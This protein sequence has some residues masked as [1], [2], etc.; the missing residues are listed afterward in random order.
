M[1]RPPWE[2][3][4]RALLRRSV[5]RPLLG[6]AIG[7]SATPAPLEDLVYTT[8]CGSM[9]PTIIVFLDLEIRA[10][11]RTLPG[12]RTRGIVSRVWS[13]W[14]WRTRN[15][16]VGR[17]VIPPRQYRVFSPVRTVWCRLQHYREKPFHPTDSCRFRVSPR[18]FQV[19]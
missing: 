7:P 18:K 10:F 3:E 16:G 12:P 6:S 19:S 9:R 4:G 11:P 5:G 8:H 15:V 2:A 13:V 1:T 17:L 14:R